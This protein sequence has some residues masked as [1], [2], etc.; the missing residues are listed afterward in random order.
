[1]MQVVHGMHACACTFAGGRARQMDGWMRRP[2]QG[3]AVEGD[4]RQSHQV[5]SSRRD[6]LPMQIAF[7]LFHRSLLRFARFP[8]GDR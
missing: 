4:D 6:V 3:D 2:D 1:M 8:V 5:R 7:A